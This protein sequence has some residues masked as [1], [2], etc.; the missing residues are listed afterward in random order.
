MSDAPAEYIEKLLGA[1]VGIEIP[2]AR[3]EGKLKASQDEAVRDRMGT[4]HGLQALAGAGDMALL[5]AGALD[6]KEGL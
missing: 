1:I 5:V 6:R 4:V 2:I 3:L